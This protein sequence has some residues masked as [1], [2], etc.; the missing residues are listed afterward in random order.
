MFFDILFFL[1]SVGLG[2]GLLSGEGIAPTT[3][4]GDDFADSGADAVEDIGV[5]G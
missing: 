2:T 1:G 3:V 4:L 5:G